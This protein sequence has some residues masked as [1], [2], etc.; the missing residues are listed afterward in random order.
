MSVT[1]HPNK[2]FSV[3]VSEPYK[4][5]L[6]TAFLHQFRV[7]EALFKTRYPYKIYIHVQNFDCKEIYSDKYNNT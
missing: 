7:V 3:P 4:V 1:A 5:G 2:G 6:T